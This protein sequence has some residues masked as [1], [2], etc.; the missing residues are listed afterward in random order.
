MAQKSGII[1]GNYKYE[2][3]GKRTRQEDKQNGTW[4]FTSKMTTVSKQYTSEKGVSREK[5]N[6]T[7]NIKMTKTRKSGKAV[8]E[9]LK[10]STKITHKGRNHGSEKKKK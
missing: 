10:W 4:K 9:L 1:K 8:Q 7:W 5:Q 3:C 6:K 2:N